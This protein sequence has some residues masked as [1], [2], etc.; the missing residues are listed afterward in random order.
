MEQ[1]TGI[2]SLSDEFFRAYGIEIGRSCPDFR[3]DS[4]YKPTSTLCS[5]AGS[6]GHEGWDDAATR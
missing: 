2:G 5:F 6:S 1:R 3:P 4:T